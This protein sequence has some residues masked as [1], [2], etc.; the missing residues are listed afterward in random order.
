MIWG[1][2]MG[3]FDDSGVIERCCWCD[4]PTGK[5]GKGEDSLYLEDGTGPYCE[6]CFES[7][8]ALQGGSDELI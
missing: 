2:R 7:F 6:D 8:E 5:A 1:S 3:L 4:A